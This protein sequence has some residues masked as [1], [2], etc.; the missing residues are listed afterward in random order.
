M[1]EPARLA[2]ATF[3]TTRDGARLPEFDRFGMFAWEDAMG[4]VGRNMGRVLSLV[5]PTL[6]L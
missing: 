6:P 1:P 4:R 3:F 2:C 5:Q